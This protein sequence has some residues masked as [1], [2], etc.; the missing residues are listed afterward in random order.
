MRG[1]VDGRLRYCSADARGE[2]ERPHGYGV[3]VINGAFALESD[4]GV[5]VSADRVGLS[6]GREGAP[7]RG[8]GIFVSGAGDTGGRL[9]VRR[10]ETDAV[11]SDAMDLRQR[12]AGPDHRRRLHGLRRAY[13][14]VVRNRGRRSQLMASTI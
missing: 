4:D 12:Y 14:D 8:S 11:Y 9:N 10:L 13:V 1:Y 6:A 5:V 3:Y 2:K 7:V